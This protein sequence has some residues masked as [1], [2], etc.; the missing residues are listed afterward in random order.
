MERESNVKEVP[1]NS[2][3]QYLLLF[4]HAN[5]SIFCF[6]EIYVKINLEEI[7]ETRPLKKQAYLQIG[8]MGY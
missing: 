5:I 2:L 8:L 1:A 7:N 6:L 3:L 4:G